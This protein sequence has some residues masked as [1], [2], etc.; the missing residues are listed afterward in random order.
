MLLKPMDNLGA[1]WNYTDTI[2]ATITHIFADTLFNQSDSIKVIS[3][4]NGDSVLLSHFN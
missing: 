1:T 2:T 3:L 4:S